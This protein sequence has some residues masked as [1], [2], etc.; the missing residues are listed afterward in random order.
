MADPTRYVPGYSYT[1]FQE[2]SPTVPLPAD[3]VDNDLAEISNAIG[4][5][6]NAVKNV[7][8]SDGKLKNRLVTYDSLSTSLRSLIF[9]SGELPVSALSVFNVA[10]AGYGAVADYNPDNPTASTDNTAAFQAAIDDA[11]TNGGTVYVP[12]GDYYFAQGSASLDPGAGGFG[13]VGEY[14]RSRLFFHEG[15]SGTPKSIIYNDEDVAKTDIYFHGI[16]FKGT[17]GQTGRTTGS[18]YTGAVFLDHYQELRFSYCRWENIY[19]MATDTHFNGYTSFDHCAFID[20]AADGARMRESFYGSVTNCYFRRL[21]DDAVAFH[22]GKYVETDGYDPDDGS[23][24]RE[25]LVCTGNVFADV[26]A[27]VTALGARQIIVEGNVANRFRTYFLFASNEA[28]E[29]THPMHSIKVRGNIALNLITGIG[30]Y[31]IISGQTPRGTTESGNI[32]PGMPASDGVFVYPWNYQSADSQK[33]EDAFPPVANLD[34]SGNE[35]GRT[36][37]AVTNYSDWGFG[38]QGNGT[39]GSDPAVTDTNL[40]PPSGLNVV[41]A[42]STTIQGNQI[43]SVTDGMYI[44]AQSNMAQAIA[45]ASIVGNTLRDFTGGGVRGTGITGKLIDLI[46]A[47]NTF[48]GDVYRLSTNS[49]ADGTYDDGTTYPRAIDL[50]TSYGATISGNNISNVAEIMQ[51]PANH[52]ISNNVV[53]ADIAA[54]GNNA[55]NKGVRNILAPEYGFTYVVA[56]CDPT[57]ANY[58]TIK[59]VMVTAAAAMPSSGYYV[60]GH[61]VANASKSLSGRTLLLGWERATTGSSHTLD[62][63]WLE[64]WANGRQELA[65]VTAISPGTIADNDKWPSSPGTVTVTGAALGGLVA[66]SYEAD[67]KGVIL[68]G[69]VSSANTVSYSFI[70]RTGAG[71]TLSAANIRARVRNS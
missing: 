50:G 53:T 67:L 45:G 64:V 61:F 24:R 27:P 42:R 71:Q 1:C 47:N 29:G 68:T 43:D 4:G 10:D 15:T 14:G 3:E 40:R 69:W 35:F 46:I 25:G 49:N 41:A 23:P 38:T 33:A 6:V 30:A 9:G 12:A 63:D 11:I 37:P 19:C 66:M 55:S 5:L 7:R 28:S 39:Y 26:S 59:N 54:L 36:L 32:V 21:G 31:V 17:F 13:M 56:D 57:S 52:A 62:T 48:D 58:G 18:N 22:G 70:N 8:R 65:G 16:T 44:N 20:V 34:I 2:S 51:N 60:K